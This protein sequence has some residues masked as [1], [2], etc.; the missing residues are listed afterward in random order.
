MTEKR[1]GTK[2]GTKENMAILGVGA[3]ACVACCAGPIV[4]F[5]AAIGL[6]TLAGFALFGTLGLVAAAVVSLLLLRRRRRQQTVCS[7]ADLAV[8]VAP[9]SM[10][11]PG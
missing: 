4:G 8:P 6:G 3:A 10:R 7:P 2:A 1:L 5:I 9:P 11:T